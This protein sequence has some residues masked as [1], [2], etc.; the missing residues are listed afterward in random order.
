M[1]P[2]HG[3]GGLAAPAFA[4]DTGA[5]ATQAL[6]VEDFYAA[7]LGFGSGEVRR[8]RELSADRSGQRI[9][10]IGERFEAGP[11]FASRPALFILHDGRVELLRDAPLASPRMSPDGR[12]I[13]F[14]LPGDQG[15]LLVG[16]ATED[17][18]ERWSCQLRGRVEHLAWS[19]SGTQVLAQVAGLGA[20]QAGLNGGT[21]PDPADDVG[22]AVS[23]SP[24][25]SDDL[26]RRLWVVDE[27]GAARCL[28]APDE[29]VWEAAWCGNDAVIVVRSADHSEDSWYDA[30]LAVIGIAGGREPIPYRARDRLGLPSASDDGRF[31]AF[32]D[33]VCSDRGLVCGTLCVFDRRT[34]G[35]H[36]PDTQGVDVSSLAFRADGRIHY[37]G[38]RSYETVVGDVHPTGA[39]AELWRSTVETCGH[40]HPASLPIGESEA[41]VVREGTILP[42]EVALLGEHGARTLF[43]TIAEP[44]PLAAQVRR[45]PLSWTGANGT[46]IDGSFLAHRDADGPLPT[47]VE[48]HGGPVLADRPRW[49]GNIRTAWLVFNGYGVLHANPRGSCGRGR[50]F[51]AAVIGDMG[52]DDARDLELGVDHAVSLGLVDPARVA[53]T[54]SSY[55]GYMSAWLATQSDRFLTAIAISPISNW[56]S[57]HGTSQIGRFDEIFLA[58]PLLRENRSPVA[59]VTQTTVPTLVLAGMRDR[60]TPPGQAQEFHRALRDVGVQTELIL[61]RDGGHSLRDLP[62]MLDAS[63]RTLDW[64]MRCGCGPGAARGG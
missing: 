37:A 46:R 56:R 15:D 16:L 43:S 52:G 17:L 39:P 1:T 57:Q 53:V 30:D 9:L 40:W 27:K 59:A 63:A 49:L 29:T 3:A 47:I 22:V 61:Y 42:P 33:A 50:D 55:G 41:L 58:D 54:G 28:S 7:C 24:S 2:E 32:V 18:T 14:A 38:L 44:V 26:W 12:S 45:T 11:A 35:L 5:G 60:N 23:V 10:F 21:M 48:V 20:D 4:T 64:L 34:G 13:V 51:A 31:V 62:I 36:R 25:D 6:S 19:P 8:I